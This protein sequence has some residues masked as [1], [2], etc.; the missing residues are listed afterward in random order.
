MIRSVVGRVA[1]SVAATAL[2]VG[3]GVVAGAGTSSAI[4]IAPQQGG[5]VTKSVENIDVS[6][7]A[8]GE[9]YGLGG[10]AAQV[11]IGGEVTFVTSFRVKSGEERLVTRITEHAPAGF[12]Y[13]PGS[14]TFGYYDAA[15]VVRNEPVTPEVGAGTLTWRAPAAGWST[16]G[17][18]LS[19]TYRVPLF[20]IPSIVE[21]G[22]VTFDVA[23]LGENVGWPTMGPDVNVNLPSNIDFMG[24]TSGLGALGSTALGSAN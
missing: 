24:S 18:S 14:A 7:Y 10:G 19:V 2:A 1:A 5:A 20:T 13:V 21:G 6:R 12:E 9:P 16:D 17:I 4:Y 23:G 22:G 3:V 15:G 11:S 8:V